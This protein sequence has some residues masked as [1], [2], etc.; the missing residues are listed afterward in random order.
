MGHELTGNECYTIKIVCMIVDVFS[1]E[2]LECTKSI[3]MKFCRY[4]LH[5]ATVKNGG[6]Y[7]EINKKQIMS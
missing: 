3:A 4:T 6:I 7:R 1:N 5:L 2:C